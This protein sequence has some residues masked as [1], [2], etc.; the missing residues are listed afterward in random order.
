LAAGSYEVTLHSGS[1]PEGRGDGVEGPSGV[2]VGRAVEGG[3]VGHL[4][5]GG[6]LTDGIVEVKLRP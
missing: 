4:Q 1:P 6:A 2:V 3:F 5:L